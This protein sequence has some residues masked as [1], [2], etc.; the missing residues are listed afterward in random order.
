MKKAHAMTSAASGPISASDGRRSENAAR[1]AAGE[2]DCVMTQD[3]DSNIEKM[4]RTRSSGLKRLDAI[5]PG[6]TFKRGATAY[7]LPQ[8][9]SSPNFVSLAATPAT[10]L[11]LMSVTP[12][13]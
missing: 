6:C 1:P 7:L 4:R 12:V 5:G 3:L 10:G 11:S 8:Q 13:S 2:V 9:L